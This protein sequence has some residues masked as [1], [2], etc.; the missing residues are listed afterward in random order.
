MNHLKPLKKKEFRNITNNTAGL[1]PQ[2]KFGQS[3]KN[4]VQQAD[5]VAERVMQMRESDAIRMQPL[6]EDDEMMM[7]TKLQMHPFNGNEE[8]FQNMPESEKMAEN[9]ITSTNPIIQMVPMPGEDTVNSMADYPATSRQGIIYDTG[10]D[11][12]SVLSRYF[13]RGIVMDVRSGYN[14]TYVVSGFPAGEEW[15]SNALKA[16]AL[17]NFN[18]NNG[19][20]DSPFVNRTTVQHLDLSSQTNPADTTIQGPNASFRFT[21]VKFDATGRGSARTENVQLLIEKLGNFTATTSTESA[22]DRRQR[23]ANTYQI[24]NAVP[25]RNDPLGDPVEAMS[26]SQ[27]DQVLDGLNQVPANLLSR[28]TG[29]P[30][31]RSLS[32]SGPRGEVAEYRQTKA[33][34][35]NTWERR[36]VVY[37]DFFRM[38][39]EQKTF[40]M[41]HE[42]GHALDFRPNEVTG[43]TGGPSSSAATGTGSFREAVRLDGGLGK[44]VS[45][46]AAT[47][48]NYD[49]Y[50]AEAFALFRTQPDT[51]RNLRP[52]V[53]Q[54]FVTQYP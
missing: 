16:L 49:E 27:F 35:S 53:Y 5:I 50:Y 51:L 8:L 29:I 45:S 24:T 21:S 54:Y 37:N 14:V 34:G 23:F 52:N 48:S 22:A 17:Y 46:Y 38:N 32:A 7:H 11:W 4:Y 31:H 15:V 40:T 30:V 36:L 44:G 13:V 20:T 47:T 28:V 18:L 3:T 9:K 25:V 12:Q 6:D 42:I 19:A 41:I 33:A 43:G 10:F 1:L 2:L 26:D 39:S